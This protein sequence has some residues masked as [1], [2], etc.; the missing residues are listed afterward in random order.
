MEGATTYR[1]TVRGVVSGPLAAAFPDM[2]LD[3]RN[4]TTV[5]A[6]E[7]RDQAQLYGLLN[8]LRD[9]GFELVRVE[10]TR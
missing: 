9:L 7:L 4:G 2:E 5:L 8:R 10:A 6:G 3:A 1:I